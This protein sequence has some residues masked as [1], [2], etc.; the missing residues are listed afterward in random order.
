MPA[1]RTGLRGCGATA[2]RRG[3]VGELILASQR[4]P[5]PPCLGQPGWRPA[6][7][8][9]PAQFQSFQALDRGFEPQSLRLQFFQDPSNVHILLPLRERQFDFVELLENSPNNRPR[10]TP[11]YSLRIVLIT[12]LFS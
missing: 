5:S 6:P 7:A 10:Y 12:R 3:L 8:A 4:A 2:F 9:L 11:R 1:S